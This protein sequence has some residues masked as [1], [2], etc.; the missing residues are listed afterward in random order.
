MA[1][2]HQMFNLIIEGSLPEIRKSVESGFNINE[3]DQYGFLLIH[4]ACAN[5][6]PEI[7][8]LLI[9]RGS[10]LEEPATDG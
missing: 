4:R 10:S 2:Y 7:V 3:P 9:E 6:R 8:R 1:T 5:H